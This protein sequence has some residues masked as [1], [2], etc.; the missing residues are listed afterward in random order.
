M[1]YSRHL[2]L[3]SGGAD[4]THFIQS[5]PTATHL[6]HFVGL[7]AD[8][9]KIAA[10]NATALNRHLDMVG[11][12][13]TAFSQRDGEINQIHALYDTQMVVAAGIKALS[14]GMR[15]LVVCFNADDI[16]IETYDQCQ[17]DP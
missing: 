10:I 16:G 11:G 14:Y 1:N 15:G 2:V 17:T 13:E 9:T 8:Q 5:E 6:I 12:G 4:S 7:N 3:Y